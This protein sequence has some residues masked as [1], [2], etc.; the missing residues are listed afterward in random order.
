MGILSGTNKKIKNPSKLEGLNQRNV[1]L[2]TGGIN[3][4]MWALTVTPTLALPRQKPP[5]PFT[6]RGL[7]VVLGTND[8]FVVRDVE[9]GEGE[10][11]EV[12]RH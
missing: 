4:S 8:A 7:P 5:P 6:C 1:W 3:L 2:K 12:V 11:E 10:P 9:A